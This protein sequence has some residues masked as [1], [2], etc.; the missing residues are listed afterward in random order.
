MTEALKYL[1]EERNLMHSD[2]K[3]D[4]IVVTKNTTP[5]ENKD[6]EYIFKLIDF[7]G[8]VPIDKKT[9]IQSY[10]KLPTRSP[11]Y[12]VKTFHEGTISYMY[13]DYCVLYSAL[14]FLG[15]P[16]HDNEFVNELSGLAFDEKQKSIK[17]VEVL[18]II[19]NKINSKYP[20]MNLPEWDSL[21]DDE[22][23]IKAAYKL[24]TAY[25]LTSPIKSGIVPNL[26]T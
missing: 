6:G 2:I 10:G 20:T 17:P 14:I 7:G 4:N 5:A 22:L 18:K 8:V 21:T 11:L 9:G 13:D 3:P 15:L 12:Y 16:R 24:L 26:A 1:H 23:K 25:I 19:I